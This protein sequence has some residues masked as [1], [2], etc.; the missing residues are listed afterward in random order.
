M[1][2]EGRR[3][4]LRL[5]AALGTIILLAAFAL[6]L[7]RAQV[8]ARAELEERFAL[9]T[10]IAAT[11]VS[12]WVDDLARREADEAGK[13]LGGPSP[14]R[15]AF[16]GLVRGLRLTAAVLLD[17]KG[18]LLQVWPRSPDLL[19]TD[20]ASN[21][22]HLT[23]A[24]DGRVAVSNVVPSA[25]A[26]T[27]VVAVAVPF[28]TSHG[29]RVFSGG[30][31]ITE[32]PIGRPY[33]SNVTPIEGS[34]VYLVDASAKPLSS[35]LDDPGTMHPDDDDLLAALRS[36]TEGTF[37]LGEDIASIEPVEGTPWRIAVAVPSESLF[38][39]IGGWSLW[40]PWIT[41]AGLLVAVCVAWWLLEK[42][43][44]NRRAL[45]LANTEL[46]ARGDQLEEAVAAQRRFISAASHELRTPLTSIIGYLELLR[47]ADSTEERG[48]ALEVVERNTKRLH[49]LVDDLMLVFRM[50]VETLAS[51]EVD[52][53]EV[54]LESVEAA[55]P[56]AAQ[57]QIHLDVK[58]RGSPAS[59]MGDRQLLAQAVDN[60][61]SNAIK[62]GLEGG[63]VE[64]IVESNRSN[65]CLSVTDGG[66]GIP[67]DELPRLF[68]RF[69]RAR[70]ARTARIGGTGLGLAIT[71][72]IIEKHGGRID[73]TSVEGEGTT[74]VVKLPLEEGARL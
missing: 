52:L 40:A 12:A 21:Y 31:S 44:R 73:V 23:A 49:A 56:A 74:F 63:R 36:R 45:A 15:E 10:Q 62:Y 70:T 47:D 68:E 1:S 67:T 24:V 28:E 51:A 25:V 18:R 57:R 5:V 3:S 37:A 61:V 34:R 72:T 20:V 64:I 50:E 71:Q 39:P 35:N 8:R 29:A 14:R 17:D 9:R 13:A 11:F 48:R 22:A 2:L 41:F 27:P 53:H 59:V 65:V 55:T 69:F 43:G 32:T 16:E 33:L 42:L 60:L 4:G 46:V 30:F 19:G 6:V 26:G 7:I 38:G 58:R 54:V 66:I